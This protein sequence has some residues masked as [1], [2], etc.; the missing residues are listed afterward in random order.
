MSVFKDRLDICNT[1]DGQILQVGSI[2]KFYR[3]EVLEQSIKWFIENRYIVYRFNCTNWV[4][5]EA[6]HDDIRDGLSFPNYY[7][8]NANAFRDCLS[9]LAVPDEGGIIIVLQRYDLF[10]ERFLEYSQYILDILEDISRYFLLMGKRFITLIQS[11]NPS[12]SY[13]DVGGRSVWWNPKE[14]LD[15]NRGL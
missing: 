1:Y 3:L 13:N 6:F 12:I 5:Q 2:C 8:R 11:N 9:D 4:T 10:T 15:K 14:W 7:G